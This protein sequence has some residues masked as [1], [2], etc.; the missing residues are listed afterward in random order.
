MINGE[1]DIKADRSNVTLSEIEGKFT[2]DANMGTVKVFANQSLLDMNINANKS[3]VFFYDSNLDGYN[4]KL[5]SQLGDIEVPDKLNASMT[6]ENEIRNVSIRSKGELIGV[7]VAI[8]V[9]SGDI[10]L[11]SR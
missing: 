4:F 6:K 9:I 5:T 2:I 8:N 11:G 1:V 7:R 3:D 10:M